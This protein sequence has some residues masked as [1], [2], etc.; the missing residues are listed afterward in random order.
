MCAATPQKLLR[1]SLRMVMS[2]WASWE[3]PEKLK[4]CGVPEGPA[5]VWVGLIG[6]MGS[7]R[8]P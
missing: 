6:R 8:V 1:N 3:V 7:L 2:H 4:S 5:D